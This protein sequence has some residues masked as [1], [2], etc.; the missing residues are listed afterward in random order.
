[1]GPGCLGHSSP[2]P[3]PLHHSLRRA[4]DAGSG[5]GPARAGTWDL[6][7]PAFPMTNTECLT[8]SSSSSCTTFSTK[9]SSACSLSSRV[10]CLM[11]WAGGMGR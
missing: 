7:L 8:C 1:M 6:P 3:T 11:T 5:L 10:L 2:L 9:L 4:Q